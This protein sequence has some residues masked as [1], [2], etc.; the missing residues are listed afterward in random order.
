[1]KRIRLIIL[2]ILLGSTLHAQKNHFIAIQ[3]QNKEPFYAKVNGNTLQSTATGHLIISKLIDSNYF[4]TIGFSK[5]AEGEKSFSIPVTKD[6]GFILRMGKD[7]GLILLN[8][9]TAQII[10][11]AKQEQNNFI[12]KD[13]SRLGAKKDNGFARLMS[14]VVND[15]AVMDNMYVAEEPKEETAK[16]EAATK[17]AKTVDSSFDQLKKN[18]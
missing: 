6:I 7:K 14:Q 4:I 1:M 16:T 15:T 18:K 9:Q 17:L 12:I 5:N 13:S 10:I 11:P 8:S 3:S 2:L